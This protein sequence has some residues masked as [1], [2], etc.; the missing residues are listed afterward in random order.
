M[1]TVR[2]K[3]ARAVERAEEAIRRALGSRWAHIPL[4]ALKETDSTN[5]RLK[6]WYRAGQIAPPYLLTADS[7]TAGRGRLGRSFV[8]PP[9]TGLYMSLLSAP[10]KGIDSGLITVLAAVAVCRAIE[11]ITALQPKIKWVNDLFLRGKKVCGILAE[12]LGGPVIIGIGVNL[13]TPPGGFPPEASPAGALDTDADAHTL[14]GRIARNILD[15]LER[16]GDPA[17]LEDYRRR[18]PLTG[19][20][21]RYTQNGQ[22]KTARVTGVAPDG[23]LMIQ[24]DAGPHIL[25]TGEV[26]IGSGAVEG[27]LQA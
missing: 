24:D 12:G 17:I 8:S 14:A 2:R 25:R 27:L 7:Q 18:M 3:E 5:L 1:S 9:G 22:E 13:R 26:T 10:P 19:H 6:E 23:G 16:P 20:M 15:G 21:I 11:E 4:Q